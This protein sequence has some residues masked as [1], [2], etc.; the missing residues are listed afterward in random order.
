M[1]NDTLLGNHIEE[2]RNVMYVKLIV[3]ESITG[4]TW[5]WNRAW[6]IV[7]P[8]EKQPI[9]IE[10]NMGPDSWILMFLT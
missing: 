5:V 8:H 7:G 10:S 1:R 9:Y 2:T 6:F 4:L 3:F